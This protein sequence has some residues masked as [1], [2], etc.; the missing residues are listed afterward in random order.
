[1]IVIGFLF[2][3][4]ILYLVC[5]LFVITENS[6]KN[7]HN[8]FKVYEISYND[9]QCFIAKVMCHKLFGIIKIYKYFRGFCRPV[10]TFSLE[11]PLEDVTC[12]Y[13]KEDAFRGLS[14]KYIEAHPTIIIK[15]IV[16]K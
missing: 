4:I 15:D 9:N 8:D 13:S 16:E 7:E 14:N 11:K 10:K 5:A 3:I 6:F 12:F 1:M 2:T